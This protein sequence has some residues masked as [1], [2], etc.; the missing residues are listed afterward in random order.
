ML[1]LLL[2]VSSFLK[3]K[4][5]NPSTVVRCVTYGILLQSKTEIEKSFG[6]TLHLAKT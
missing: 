3:Y 4:L 2:Y 6:L 1:L 5:Q